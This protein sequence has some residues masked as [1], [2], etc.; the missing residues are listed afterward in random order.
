MPLKQPAMHFLL[1]RWL[2][3]PESPA[4]VSVRTEKGDKLKGKAFLLP[5]SCEA[6]ARACGPKEM[7]G[8][9]LLSLSIAFLG[10]LG[11]EQM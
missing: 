9:S 5:T 4:E 3:L 8:E 1:R 7:L 11:L 2:V 6:F 10:F